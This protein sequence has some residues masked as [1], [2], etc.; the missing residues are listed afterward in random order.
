MKKLVVLVVSC[1]VLV[2]CGGSG[3]GGNNHVTLADISGVWDDSYY[4]PDEVEDEDEAYFV[5]KSDG[6]Y[7]DYD[8]D[9]DEE[10]DG[11]DCYF[12]NESTITDLGNGKFRFSY[13]GDVEKTVSVSKSGDNLVF[14]FDDGPVEFPPATLLET[15]FTPICD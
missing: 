8:Y 6:T 4:D 14:S 1:L 15:E 5:I 13:W 7:I 3:S 2:S 11:R 9:G 10:G 12:I